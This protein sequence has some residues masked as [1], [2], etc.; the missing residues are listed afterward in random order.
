MKA[1]LP[2]FRRDESGAATIEYVILL[3]PL[4]A[5][6]FTSFQIAL[7]YH[8]ALTAQKA[9][10][11]GARIAAVR[12]PVHTGMPPENAAAPGA[13]VGDSCA[14]GGCAAPGGPWRCS[15]SDLGSADCD[16]AGVTTVRLS[17]AAGVPTP[18][19]GILAIFGSK[20]NA[21]GLPIEDIEGLVITASETVRH[22]GR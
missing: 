18:A 6:V 11:L 16:A 22:F 9:V 13:R 1:R 7:A 10:E 2:S 14:L 12:D 21:D 15:G 17:A 19:L 3:L 4:I 8:F 20:T 5:L